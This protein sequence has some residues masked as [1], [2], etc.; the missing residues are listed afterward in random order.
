MHSLCRDFSR[1]VKNL[2]AYK[3]GDLKYFS[4]IKGVQVC[5]YDQISSAEARV[6][7]LNNYLSGTKGKKK[8]DKRT[9]LQRRVHMTK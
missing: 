5:M 6:K 9:A 2:Q 1:G 7:N 3:R 8:M 4:I